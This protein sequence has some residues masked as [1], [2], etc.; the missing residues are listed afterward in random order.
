M[1]VPFIFECFMT[2]N[3]PSGVK[4]HLELNH[5][6]TKKSDVESNNCSSGM[7][8][9]LMLLKPLIW[10]V[11]RFSSADCWTEI[12]LFSSSA[13]LCHGTRTSACASG[14]MA[15]SLSLTSVVFVSPVVSSKG[16]S[17]PNPVYYLCLWPLRGFKQAWHWLLLGLPLCWLCMLCRR[18]GT[19]CRYVAVW[20]ITSI[21]I[22]AQV[23]NRN[24]NCNHESSVYH[25]NASST[26]L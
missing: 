3:T 14:G 5:L 9:F 19:A 11:K 26:P 16:C 18:S 20:C 4:M 12:F 24:S 22:P 2:N 23:L 17:L 1:K 25:V 15:P 10:W 13:S 8:V 7:S 6:G 21:P